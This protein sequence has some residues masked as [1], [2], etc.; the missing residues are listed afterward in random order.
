MYTPNKQI[1]PIDIPYEIQRQPLTLML[2]NVILNEII[3]GMI[4]VTAFSIES[5]HAGLWILGWG[6][7]IIG[8]IW[9]L[10]YHWSKQAPYL[11]LTQDEVMFFPAM[12]VIPKFIRR[13]RIQ[14]IRI[15]KKKLYISVAGERPLKIGFSNAMREQMN[16]MVQLLNEEITTRNEQKLS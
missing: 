9:A 16:N 4:L 3:G 10:N 14:Q 13:E 15:E 1:R 8:L 7:I 2:I 11:R 6:D 5:K 12:G